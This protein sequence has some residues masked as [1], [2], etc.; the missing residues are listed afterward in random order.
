MANPEAIL[1]NEI[2]LA[3]GRERDLALWRNSAGVAEAHG[4]KI[5]FGLVTGASD[6]IGIGPGGRFFAL[7][8]KTPTGRP[9]PEQLQFI[10]LIRSRGGFA[11]IVRSV[12]DAR[13]ALERARRGECQ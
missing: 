13:S 5:R 1:Q 10:E 3:L 2:R 8:V 7:E 9:T 6:L 4:R 12:E 11:C